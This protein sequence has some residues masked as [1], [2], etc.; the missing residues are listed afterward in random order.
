MREERAPHMLRTFSRNTEGGG[1]W[2]W[3]AANTRRIQAGPAQGI[4]EITKEIRAAFQKS[5]PDLVWEITPDPSAPWLFCV[6]ADGNPSLFSKV[7]EAVRSAPAIP[8][9]RI[10]AFRARGSLNAKLDIGGRT[11]GYDDIWCRVTA[12]NGRFC[13]TLCI[14]GLTQQTN[15][16]LSG[17]AAVLLDN[18]V[19]E[20]DAVTKIERLERAALPTNP[21]RAPDFFPLAELPR[22]L[23]RT[24]AN[25]QGL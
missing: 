21:R 25:D 19:G 16:V 20:F 14:R 13:V 24:D 7:K 12:R 18:A 22:F 8:G 15:E 11:L 4:S 6:S 3:L 17:G 10:Q 23:D 2:H 9:W 1:F 5:Y